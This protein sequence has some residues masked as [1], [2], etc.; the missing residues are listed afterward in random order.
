MPAGDRVRAGL[1]FDLYGALLTEHQQDV[2]QLYYLDDWSLAEIG[3]A[4]Q[5]SRAAV[6]D[7]LERTER[8]LEDYE[9]RLGLLRAHERRVRYLS[10]ALKQIGQLQADDH[11]VLAA[12][13]AIRQ[14]A[15]EE[16]LSDV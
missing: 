12:R 5:I 8:I 4:Q 14:L 3:V 16:G 11:R 6:H 10:D 9:Q 2:W 13:A 1:L 15:Q 7:L